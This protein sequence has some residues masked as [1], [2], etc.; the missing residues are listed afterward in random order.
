MPSGSQWYL[1][2]WNLFNWWIFFVLYY[3]LF[4]GNRI[5]CIAVAQTINS[6]IWIVYRHTLKVYNT[7]N[8]QKLGKKQCYL[9]TIYLH[10]Y[11][12]LAILLCTKKNTWKKKV[13]MGLQSSKKEGPKTWP[14]FSPYLSL[15]PPSMWRSL[16]CLFRKC[17]FM[18]M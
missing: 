17:Q 12:F 14:F 4:F 15:S 3:L 13:R 11:Y 2:I 18:Q 16:S 1:S 10:S 8:K 5:L 6:Q 7:I 9:T